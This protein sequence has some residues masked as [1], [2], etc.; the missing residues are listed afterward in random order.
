VSIEL[1]LILALA[2]HRAWRLLAVDELPWAQRFRRWLEGSTAHG[3]SGVEY[4]QRPLVRKWIEC[5]WCSGAW[6]SVVAYVA[7]RWGGDVAHAVLI[8][9]ATSSLVGVLVRNF[10]PT[11]D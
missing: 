2:T 4:V 3:S 1:V 9:A 8:I 5:P 11:E 6:L 10:D 7:W